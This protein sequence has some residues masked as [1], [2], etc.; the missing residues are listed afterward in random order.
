MSDGGIYWKPAD[1][2]SESELLVAGQVTQTPG[3]WFSDGQGL[4]YSARA[5]NATGTQGDIWIFSVGGESEPFLATPFNERAPRLSP[6]RQWLA[7]VS[8]QSGADRVYVQPFP[9]GGRVIP[10]SSGN[11]T[12]PVWS[13]DGRELFYRDGDQ[14][15]AVGL[16]VGSDFVV[17]RPEVLFR[18]EYGADPAGNGQPNYDVALDGQRFLMTG[19][20]VGDDAPKLNIV[21]N[22]FDE[23]QRLVPTP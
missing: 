18:R 7:Y 21:L 12:E 15:M 22:W 16:E 10:V 1:A 9:Q 20:A 14:I 17:G 4:V 5:T 23:L 2:S 8:D 19:R 3:S 13:R 6:N 11:G